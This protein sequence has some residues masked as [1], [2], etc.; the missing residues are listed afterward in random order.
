VESLQCVSLISLVTG[1]FSGCLIKHHAMK[2]QG[3]GGTAPSI[4]NVDTRRRRAVSFTPWPLYTRVRTWVGPKAGIGPFEKR[5]I[6]SSCREVNKT[7][8][9]S[10]PQPG[11]YTERSIAV[12]LVIGPYSS[13]W[14]RT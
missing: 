3:S 14:A 13:E 12:C 1:R 8:Y 6:S 2:S 4:L 7:S 9:C 11:Y 5:T 10:T